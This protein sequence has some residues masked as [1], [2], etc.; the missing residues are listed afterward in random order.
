MNQQSPLREVA[1]LF[2]KL[3]LIAF[4][5]PAAHIAMM[6]EEVVTK[7][8]WVTRQHFLDLVG[9]TNLI[10]GPNSTEMTMHIGYERAG[11]PGLFVGG[12]FFILPAALITGIFAWFYVTYG[13]LP[14]VEPFLIGI[15][16][17]VIAIILSAVWKLGKKAIKGWRLATIGVALAIAV[18]LG[19]NEIVA[20]FVGAIVGA[21][22]LR[23]DRLGGAAS[24]LPAFL[25]LGLFVQPEGSFIDSFTNFA[26]D[27]AASVAKWGYHLQSAADSVPL[28]KL[29][30]FFLKVGAVLYGSGYVLVAFLEGDLVQTYGWLTQSQLLDAIA[31]G[32]LTPGPLLTT[33]TFIGYILG[34]V[35]GAILGTL[36]I[37]LPSLLFV[38]ILNPLVPKMRKSPLAAAFLDAVNAAAVALMVAVTIRLGIATLINWQ[39]WLIFGLAT[40][41]VLRFQVGALWLVVGG[42]ILGYLL[43]FIG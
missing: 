27:T 35:P 40:V 25:P 3:G 7:R 16:P 34:G 23:F 37:F 5:G 32:Q 28:G 6:E 13:S 42:A 36:G 20:L 8:G 22:W 18:L 29:F 41:A 43:T 11:R 1:A 38:L 39:A 33:A 10:P 12:G 4:G 15:K 26:L 30:L 21:L 19:V 17:A 9:A 24:L 31:I 2:I 14:A